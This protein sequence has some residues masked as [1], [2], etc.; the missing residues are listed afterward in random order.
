VPEDANWVQ[1][2]L[3]YAQQPRTLND[4]RQSE[5]RKRA[6]VVEKRETLQGTIGCKLMPCSTIKKAQRYVHCAF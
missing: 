3:A 1:G 5:A 2:N 6:R 4:L